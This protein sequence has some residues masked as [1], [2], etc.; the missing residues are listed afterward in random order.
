VHR[1]VECV[2]CSFEPFEVSEYSGYTSDRFNGRIVW[3]KR[4]LNIFGFRHR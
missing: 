3:M 1:A 4:E 2:H